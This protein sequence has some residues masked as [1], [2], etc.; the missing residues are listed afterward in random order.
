MD[1]SLVDVKLKFIWTV[2][3]LVA[4]SQGVPGEKSIHTSAHIKQAQIVLF[5]RNSFNALF[6]RLYVLMT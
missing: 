5:V 4:F 1:L 2:F 3:L 6:V